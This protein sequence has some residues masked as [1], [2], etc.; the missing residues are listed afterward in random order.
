MRAA[1]ETPRDASSTKFSYNI[2]QSTT[3]TANAL[4]EH[5]RGKSVFLTHPSRFSLAS[6]AAME[7]G[8]VCYIFLGATV[9][10]VSAPAGRGRY[11]LVGEACEW[12]D[13]W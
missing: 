11:R 13:G 7:V 9:P 1:I 5:H 8:D 10:F 3:S 2:S 4:R 6:S 12:S